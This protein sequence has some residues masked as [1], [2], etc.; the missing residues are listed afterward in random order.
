MNI[1]QSIYCKQQELSER[2]V[3]RFTGFHPN[4]GKLLLYACE[5]KVLKKAIAQNIRRENFRVSPK[6]HKNRK[7]F[8]SC[9]FCRLQ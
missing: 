8:L 1:S 5:L 3:S 7:T 4:V 9:N 6:I 2:K